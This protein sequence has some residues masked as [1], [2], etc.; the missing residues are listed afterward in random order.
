M[1]SF[2]L[3]L[4]SHGTSHAGRPL[5]T[6]EE[7]ALA[8]A[9]EASPLTEWDINQMALQLEPGEVRQRFPLHLNPHD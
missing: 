7:A 6:D 4:F 9:P 1:D 8:D 2:A 3:Q 5:S